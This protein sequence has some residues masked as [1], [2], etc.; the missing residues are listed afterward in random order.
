M[1]PVKPYLIRAI[2]EWIID[3]DLSPYINVDTTIPLVTVPEQ[4]IENNS[5][6]LDI[7][8]ESVNE[9]LID[10]EAM[11]FQARFTGK[12]NDIYLPIPSIASIY[13]QENNQGMAFPK[14]EEIFAGESKKP[15]STKTKLD[16]KIIDGGKDRIKN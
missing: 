7:S 9:L 4:H 16:L 8:P 6:T 13:A 14:E 2:Y 15:K 12:V 3:N 5:I 10:N 11:T 1:F